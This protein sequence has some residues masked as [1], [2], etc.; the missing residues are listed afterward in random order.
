MPIVRSTVL[1]FIP[2][3]V[4]NTWHALQLCAHRRFIPTCVGNTDILLT[5]KE[6]STVHPHVCGEYA[7]VAA[8]PAP[9][10]RFIPTCVGNTAAACCMRI[11]IDGSSPRV[12]G[13]REA[14][15]VARE[16]ARFIPT[17]V[18]NTSNAP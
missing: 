4:G 16:C 1:R 15:S 7:G 6:K 17:C 18:G 9:A 10:P 8:P 13:I 5:S 3:C 14:Q 12:W 2:T 11:G